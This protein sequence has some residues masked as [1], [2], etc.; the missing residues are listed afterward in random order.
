M[1]KLQ[2]RGI[3][4]PEIVECKCDPLD[5]EP[6]QR[7]HEVDQRLRRTLGKFKDQPVRRDPDFSAQ[8]LYEV[9]E[10]ELFQAQRRNVHRD[11]NV[12][13][14]AL[15]GPPLAKR[16]LKHPSRQFA[17]QPMFLGKRNE[18]GRGHVA[19]IRFFPADQRLDAQ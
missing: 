2:K 17:D 3:T 1:A 15:P 14:L 10:I 19:Q 13:P 6:R 9:R 18:Q 5:A 11:A 8:A 12:E 4:G 16:G 7:V